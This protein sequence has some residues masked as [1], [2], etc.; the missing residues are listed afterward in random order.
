MG[1][2][3]LI[4]II[5]YIQEARSRYETSVC[6][7][8]YYSRRRIIE[9]YFSDYLQKRNEHIQV[10]TIHR[11]APLPPLV[12]PMVV[13]APNNVAQQDL[14]FPRV[15]FS[16]LPSPCGTPMLNGLPQHVRLGTPCGNIIVLNIVFA[17]TPG[18][19]LWRRNTRNNQGTKAIPVI[20]TLSLT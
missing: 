2:F 4:T 11:I 13:C 7:Y 10:E 16:Q 17:H 18:K 9:I 6:L 14:T 15:T 20:F 1:R 8:R 19:H 12:S 5:T 3:L